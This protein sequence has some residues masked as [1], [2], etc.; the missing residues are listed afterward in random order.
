MISNAWIK[1]AADHEQLKKE[2]A[3][4]RADI[5]SGILKDHDKCQIYCEEIYT[6][7]EAENEELR[8]VFSDLDDPENS[9][10]RYRGKFIIQRVADYDADMKRYYTARAEVRRLTADIETLLSMK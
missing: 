8:A 6:K 10:I 2:N 1:L 9:F 7:L 4:L 3:E 5:F